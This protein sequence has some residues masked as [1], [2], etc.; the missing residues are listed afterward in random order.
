MNRIIRKAAIDVSM[1]W[2]TKIE[3]RWVLFEI[4]LFCNWFILHPPHPSHPALSSLTLLLGFGMPFEWIESFKRPPATALWHRNENQGE[5]SSFWN[6]FILKSFNYHLSF[7][8][9]NL[10]HPSNLLECR[11]QWNN[12]TESKRSGSLRGNITCE[13]YFS[14]FITPISCFRVLTKYLFLLILLQVQ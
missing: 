12:Q 13:H 9:D 1:A 14:T 10:T 4:V 11:V 6:H 5:L 8:F 7:S 3:E 2:Q